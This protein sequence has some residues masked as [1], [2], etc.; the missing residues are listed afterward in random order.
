MLAAYKPQLSGKPQ[1]AIQP[2]LLRWLLGLTAC[3]FDEGV[4]NSAFELLSLLLAK[5]DGGAATAGERWP[6]L[7]L[8]AEYINLYGTT[9][10]LPTQTSGLVMQRYRS[11]PLSARAAATTASGTEVRS[12]AR[13]PVGKRRRREIE[14]PG[15]GDQVK[16]GFKIGPGE[17]QQFFDGEVVKTATE[18]SVPRDAFVFSC[19]GTT[20]GLRDY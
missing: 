4:A 7:S 15:V 11:E 17:E 8:I 19:H 16:V 12:P 13:P 3:S 6:Q 5:I 14:V 2:A 10:A 18:G 20:Y 9:R 1:H